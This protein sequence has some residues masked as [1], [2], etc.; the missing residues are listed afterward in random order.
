M[1]ARPRRCLPSCES[2]QEHPQAAFDEI[3]GK[4]ARR[5]ELIGEMPGEL[6]LQHGDGREAEAVFPQCGQ[7]MK[8]NRRPTRTVIHAEA[9]VKVKRSHR[10][11]HYQIGRQSGRSATVKTNWHALVPS[12]R[13]CDA[14]T[15]HDSAQSN[16]ASAAST[17]W[18]DLT[19]NNLECTRQRIGA[20]HWPQI[21][22]HCIIPP[23]GAARLSPP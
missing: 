19:H 12:G 18:L 4:A 5:R 7:E 10:Q 2:G 8:S 11:R 21:S 1:R 3:A 22:N 23:H 16:L 13:A 9:E 17:A 15:P 14:R 20:G 6:L